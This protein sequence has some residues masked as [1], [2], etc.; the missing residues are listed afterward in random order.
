MVSVTF[1]AGCVPGQVAMKVAARCSLLLYSHM[2]HLASFA[3]H[4]LPSLVT[5]SAISLKI[6]VGTVTG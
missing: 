6:S 5:L 4:T 2:T 3:V 1:L